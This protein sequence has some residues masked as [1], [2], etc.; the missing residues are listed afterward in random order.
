LETPRITATSRYPDGDARS[1]SVAVLARTKLDWK[2]MQ[3]SSNDLPYEF[4][5]IGGRLQWL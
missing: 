3:G 1:E 4:H 2:S 5:A